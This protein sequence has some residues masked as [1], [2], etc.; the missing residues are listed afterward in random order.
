M[1]ITP[2]QP[3]RLGDTPGMGSYDDQIRS[4]GYIPS[5]QKPFSYTEADWDKTSTAKSGTTQSSQSAQPTSPM[6]APK[7]AG[8]DAAKVAA[9]AGVPG[10]PGVPGPVSTAEGFQLY[11]TSK[12]KEGSTT[13]TGESS[14][15][16]EKTIEDYQKAWQGILPNVGP[17]TDEKTYQSEVYDYMLENDPEA[18]AQMWQTY[19]ITNKGKRSKELMQLTKNKEGEFDEETLKD[20]ETLKKLKEAYVDGLA[21]VRTLKPPVQPPVTPTPDPEKTPT[22]DITGGTPEPDPKDDTSKTPEFE[23]ATGTQEGK[24]IKQAFPLEQAIPGMMGLAA[25]QETFAY[26]IPEVDAPY[27]RPQELNIQSQVQDIDNMSQAA[28]RSGADPL[29]VTINAGNAKENLYRR[30]QNFDAMGRTRA[31]MFNAQA[32]IQK[33]RV[34]AASFDRTYNQMYAQARD[35]ATAEKQAAITNLITNKAKHDQ[36]ENIKKAYIDNLTSSYIVGKDSPTSFEVS[37]RQ[38]DLVNYGVSPDDALVTSLEAD[39]EVKKAQSKKAKT[40]K[41]KTKTTNK[42]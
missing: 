37:E 17:K 23:S 27:I 7:T 4:L 32:D 1:L 18:I 14:F 11:T 35:A 33:Q 13:P 30:K 40:R 34:N 38:G 12:T 22:P 9:S 24:Y 36:S 31:D 2:E 6:S 8:A 15:A 25:A 26:A 10:V 29:A 19:G 39:T 42:K 3:Q 5:P 28:I 16:V 41:T 21:G 20:P